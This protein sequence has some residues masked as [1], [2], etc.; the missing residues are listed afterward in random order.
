[1]QFRKLLIAC[2]ISLI[3]L[4]LAS[5]KANADPISDFYRQGAAAA[6]QARWQRWNSYTPRQKQLSRAISTIADTYYQQNGQ[7]LPVDKKSLRLIMNALKATP[8]EASFILNRMV[9][10]SNAYAAI[11]PTNSIINRTENFLNCLNTQGTGCIP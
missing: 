5:M 4:P 2:T 9:A 1:M 3:A 8:E 10:Y 11:A 6:N 7:P